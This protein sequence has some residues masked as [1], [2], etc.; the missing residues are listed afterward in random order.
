MSS[1][2]RRLEAL[3][4]RI[5]RCHVCRDKLILQ[6]IAPD[7]ETDEPR[8]VSEDPPCPQCGSPK[9]QVIRIVDEETSLKRTVSVVARPRN[10]SLM[11]SGPTQGLRYNGDDDGEDY[12]SQG[13]DRD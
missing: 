8:V 2:K 6:V 3:T 1:L 5:G 4:E 12:Y 10:T 13:S 11:D 7:P 9:K